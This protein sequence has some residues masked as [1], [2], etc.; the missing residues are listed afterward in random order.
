MFA[1]PFVLGW[2]PRDGLVS[3]LGDIGL[4]YLMFL[5][6]LSFNIR[7]F[8]ENRSN[9]LVFG[10]LGFFIPFGLS[11]FFSVSFIGLP[12]L[13]AML[14]GAMW[15]SNTLIAYPDV[16]AAGL[17]NKKAVS[18]AVSA[19]VV[20]DLFSLTVLGVVTS[21]V[22][23]E[24][25]AIQFVTPTTENPTLPIWLGLPLLAGFC[26]WLLPKVTEWFFVKVGHTR[27]QR[28]VFALAGM[29]AGA[30]VALLGG[31]EGL[32]G[33]FLAGLGM[34]S[35]IPARSALMDRI[36]FVGGAIFVPAFLVSIGL[37]IDPRAIFDP[38]T[39]LLALAFT[40]LVVVGKT[41]AAVVT[42]RI[43]K[44]SAMDI[45]LMASLSMG[46]AASTLA[47]A[48]VGVS[49][50][51]FDREVFNAAILTVVATAFI[52]SYG[53]RFFAHRVERPA[54]VQ[55]PLGDVVLV[56]VR[57]NGSDI[58]ALMTVAGAIARKDRGVVTPYMVPNPGGLDLAKLRVEEAVRAVAAAGH[59]ASGEIRVDDSFAAGTL[60]LA[61]EV[62]STLTI[63]DW[64][65]SGMPTNLLFGNE[66]DLVGARSSTPAAAIRVLR[67]WNRIVVFTGM[68]PDDWNAED[69]WLA[70]D[71]ARRLGTDRG[72]KMLVFTPDLDTV[73]GRIEPDDDVEIMV[74]PG[75]LEQTFDRI[76]GDDLIVTPTHVVSSVGTFE[77][78]RIAKALRNVSVMVVAGPH[79]LSVDGTSMQRNLHGVVD[80]TEPRTDAR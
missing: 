48:Q 35:L 33:A 7:A 79:R 70:L 53:T 80:M 12:V 20:A 38:D 27:V 22:V 1:G 23:I 77:Q 76:T 46:Q 73:K 56:D 45:G 30:S 74:E 6:G 14:V 65:A 44:L 78:L 25:E 5:A 58:N 54:A 36:D 10:L 18:T 39:L 42:G 52:T 11:Y 59:D 29:S 15:A 47:I 68:I 60:N 57:P 24:L 51:L 34:N 64:R 32:I 71:I 2:I 26:L 37:S 63:L 19:G 69:T 49:L 55:A 50:N 62:G 75:N 67:P 3:D 9:A 21:S 66:I 17:Q 4:L 28:F 41:T 40:A 13:G 72:L 16:L 31:I 8:A 43:F 61:E